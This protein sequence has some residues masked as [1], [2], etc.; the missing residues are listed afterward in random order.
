MLKAG[1]AITAGIGL[2][3]YFLFKNILLGITGIKKAV[4]K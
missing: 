1:R 4:N 3:K 2:K